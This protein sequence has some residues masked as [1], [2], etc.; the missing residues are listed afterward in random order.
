MPENGLSCNFAAAASQYWTPSSSSPYPQISAQRVLW[1][2]SRN[3][4]ARRGS[5]RGALLAQLATPR[6]A[7]KK[8]A[9]R[10]VGFLIARL[11]NAHHPSSA[12][13]CPRMQL[14]SSLPVKSSQPISRPRKLVNLAFLSGGCRRPAGTRKLSK[15]R[16][17]LA[18]FLAG[19][20]DS[21]VCLK[22]TIMSGMAG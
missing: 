4:S 1:F 22:I 7:S 10:K 20:P 3:T 14:P 15:P 9:Q 12:A 5:H 17:A 19:I 16:I 2:A 6:P 21:R 11:S 18:I 8:A 13:R